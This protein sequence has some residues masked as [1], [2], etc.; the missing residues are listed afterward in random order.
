MSL[1]HD[2]Q[3][4]PG[5]GRCNQEGRNKLAAFDI[6]K[7]D[8]TSAQTVGVDKDRRTSVLSLTPGINA[9]RFQSLEKRANRSFA[10]PRIA[11]KTI[12]P[13]PEC[14]QGCEKAHSCPI[15]SKMNS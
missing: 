15:V 14:S 9:Q 12:F 5:I 7:M 1:K 8:F 11:G 2:L 3:I 6:F 4:F 10:K 13:L